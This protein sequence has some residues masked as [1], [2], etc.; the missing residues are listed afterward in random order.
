MNATDV[1][2]YTFDQDVYC[3][4]CVKDLEVA[5]LDE[6]YLPQPLFACAEVSSAQTCCECGHRIEGLTVLGPKRYIVTKPVYFSIVVE[7]DDEDDAMMIALDREESEWEMDDCRPSLD[8]S[9]L[10][11]CEVK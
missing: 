5:G 2:A 4:V 10:N 6:E 7:A 3:D 1:V 9:D 8:E 11:V